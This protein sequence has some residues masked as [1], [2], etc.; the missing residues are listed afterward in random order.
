MSGQKSAVVLAV[1]VCDSH[2]KPKAPYGVEREEG[3]QKG[4][5]ARHALLRL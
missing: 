1:I 5:S 3:R 2:L 4:G